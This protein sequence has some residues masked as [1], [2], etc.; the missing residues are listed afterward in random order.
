MVGLGQSWAQLL[1]HGDFAIDGLLVLQSQPIS[2][3]RVEFEPVGF[4]TQPSV[5]LSM[6]STTCLRDYQAVLLGAQEVELERMA[7]AARPVD[8]CHVR[9][10]EQSFARC[11]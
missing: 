5:L 9:H 2:S 3:L 11:T 1:E 7:D 4:P 10:D 6:L 8:G